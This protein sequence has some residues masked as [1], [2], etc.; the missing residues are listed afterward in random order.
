ME[1]FLKQVAD[2]VVIEQRRLFNEA[3]KVDTVE[4]KSC[5]LDQIQLLLVAIKPF[6]LL[7]QQFSCFLPDDFCRMFR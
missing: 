1:T 4:K 7:S 2:V 6:F 3:Q 5:I